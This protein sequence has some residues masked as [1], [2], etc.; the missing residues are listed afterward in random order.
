MQLRP[1]QEKELPAIWLIL[2]QAIEQRRLDGSTQW[3]DGYPNEDSIRHDMAIGAAY[4]LKD[5][6]EIV[7]Y[8]ALIFGEDP[9]Y[10][11]IQGQWLT[12]GDYLV[13]HRLATSKARKKQGYAVHL[14]GLLEK[15]CL[16]RGVYSIKVDTNFDNKAMLHILQK[17][18]YSYCGEVLMRGEARLAFEKVL[19]AAD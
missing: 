11:D 12:E 5:A 16:A 1:A 18:K 10:N 2:Q 4:V 9:A 6:H 13:V 3:Q 17:L 15:L 8:V 7:A 19:S 14:F